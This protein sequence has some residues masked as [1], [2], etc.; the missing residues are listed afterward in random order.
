MADKTTTELLAS[1][2]AVIA[3]WDRHYHGNN[4]EAEDDERGPIAEA[5]RVVLRAEFDEVTDPRSTEHDLSTTE[6]R[7]AALAALGP[8]AY[9][10]LHERYR[11]SQVV[12]VVNGYK[13]RCVPSRWGTFYQFSET[14]SDMYT[15]VR[16]T[17]AEA[18]TLA[19][20]LPAGPHTTP[21]TTTT[22][23]NT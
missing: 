20:S 12:A 1:L 23:D 8:E 6:G 14:G 17:Q 2:K 7:R 16:G 10:R 13:I 19:W 18:E 15:R 22:G 9:A 11:E 3:A 5:R 4:R 21:P